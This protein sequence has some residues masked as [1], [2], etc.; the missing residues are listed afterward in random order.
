M[1]TQSLA[2]LLYGVSTRDALSFLVVPC[3]VM[4]VSFA[5]CALPAWRATRINPIDA[6][7]AS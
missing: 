3:A 2:A 6:L 7:R 4:F 1:L 5:A